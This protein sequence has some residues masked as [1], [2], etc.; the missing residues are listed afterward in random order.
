M[1]KTNLIVLQVVKNEADHSHDLLLVREVKNFGNM[2]DDIQF[3]VLEQVHRELVIAENPEAAADIVCDLSILLALVDEQF[4]KDH[5]A[6][7][8]DE[9]LSE[10]V[11][12]EQVHQAVCVG[13]ARQSC[14]LVLC[15]KQEVQ[16]VDSL[17]TEGTFIAETREA[18]QLGKSVSC[19]VSLLSELLIDRLVEE[20]IQDTNA[21]KLLVWVARLL[22]LC[23]ILD[24]VASVLNDTIDESQG[25]LDQFSLTADLAHDRQQSAKQ[26]HDLLRVL[27]CIKELSLL[28]VTH[29][30]KLLDHLC[31]V[32]RQLSRCLVI[33]DG[34][35]GDL[36]V[37]DLGADACLLVSENAGVH[38]NLVGDGLALLSTLAWIL[39]G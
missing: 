2:L 1:L 3:K 34:V 27:T 7:F 35:V 21:V 10:L 32:L 4:V 9:L 38:E 15:L 17:V 13:S 18:D 24:S 11:D 6:A 23:K 31:A 29:S 37:E 19:H 5:E 25:P 39:C 28:L 33:L 30:L 36:I 26:C 8:V 22:D 12:P 20:T 14:S 16:E